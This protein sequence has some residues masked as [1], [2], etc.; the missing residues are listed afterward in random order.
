M[1]CIL[2]RLAFS[3]IFQDW[4]FDEMQFDEVEF[5]LKLHLKYFRLVSIQ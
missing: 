5:Y 4:L 3:R 2:R 1:S